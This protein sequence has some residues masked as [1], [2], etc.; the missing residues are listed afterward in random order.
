[1]AC[2][3]GG[4]SDN[5]KDNTSSSNYSNYSSSSSI[6]FLSSS[7]NGGD[8]VEEIGESSGYFLHLSDPHL[9]INYAENASTECLLRPLGATC[10][11]ADDPVSNTSR[12]AGRY[13][14]VDC[15]MPPA[16]MDEMLR[17]AAATHGRPDFVLVTGD[18]TSHDVMRATNEVCLQTWRWLFDRL[19][20]H[21]GAGVRILAT[22]GNHDL[23]LP[24]S[25]KPNATILA[26]TAALFAEYGVLRANDERDARRAAEVGCFV[27]HYRNEEGA[28]FGVVVL[29]SLL[30]LSQNTAVDDNDPG[31]QLAWLRSVVEEAERAGEALYVIGHVAPS[32]Q[33][34]S[35]AWFVDAWNKLVAEHPDTVRAGFF[36][37]THYDQMHFTGRVAALGDN[38]TLV[39]VFLAPAATPLNGI[40][41]SVRVVEYD[42]HSQ[43]LLDMHVSHVNVTRANSELAVT[44]EPFYSTRTA[45]S[46]PDMSP[47]SLHTLAATLLTSEDQAV[48]YL[49]RQSTSG[50]AS[51][52]SACDE[53]CRRSLY[54][55]M[56]Y[57]NTTLQEQCK[58]ATTR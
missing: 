15:D 8:G 24:N 3:A 55:T 32:T 16:L 14:D 4:G 9:D 13:G 52:T 1:M 45:Y 49:R 34:G 31:G 17:R 46:L 20:A 47:D 35:R 28:R 38:A 25:V 36:G 11:H 23:F 44:L 48:A 26:D 22:M 50:S 30:Y 43:Q 6:G 56:S 19:R 5:N 57:T 37:H 53:S 42:T 2:T 18:A 40:W 10:C 27:R 12:Q 21:F 39:P 58:A 54:C 51:G 33:G 7:S 29:N 41:P